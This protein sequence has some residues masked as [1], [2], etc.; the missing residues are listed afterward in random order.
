MLKAMDFKDRYSLSNLQ[1]PGCSNAVLLAVTAVTAT[2]RSCNKKNVCVLG[3]PTVSFN[4]YDL[5]SA[6]PTDAELRITKT[7]LP[8]MQQ[9]LAWQTLF[10][11][12]QVS[13]NFP[14]NS[15]VRT[16]LALAG[17]IHLVS[18]RTMCCRSQKSLERALTSCIPSL[19]A[20]QPGTSVTA[21]LPPRVPK[22]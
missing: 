13:R 6:K 1:L 14:N 21:F 17:L 9:H 3:S 18:L 4:S 11:K 5:R 20:L 7:T 12:A 2:V 15:C 22:L 8:R 19:V 10:P 16:F